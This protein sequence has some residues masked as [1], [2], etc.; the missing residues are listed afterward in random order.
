MLF[1]ALKQTFTVNHYLRFRDQSHCC[2]HTLEC[3]NSMWPHPILKETK[4]QVIIHLASPFYI[5]RVYFVLF[6]TLKGIFHQELNLHLIYG[7]KFADPLACFH[8]LC[9]RTCFTC[10]V[11][12]PSILYFRPESTFSSASERCLFAS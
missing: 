4:D 1:Q 9:S 12:V 5:Y 8:I 11:H 10:N 6:V 3:C 2:I 7:L